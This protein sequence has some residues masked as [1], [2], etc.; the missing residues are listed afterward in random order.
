MRLFH[1]S[2]DAGPLAIDGSFYAR[3]ADAEDARTATIELTV[4]PRS[5]LAWPVRRGQICRI[6]TVEGP[7]AGDFN[8]WSL[9]N[10]RER[11]WAARTRQL[12]GTHVT[13]LGRLWSSRPYHRPMLTIIN[14]TLPHEP[15]ELGGRCH[16]LIGTGCDP[17]IWKLMNGTDFDRTCYNNLARAIAPFHLTEF[18]VHDVLNLF[19]RTGLDPRSGMY[20]M[21]PVPAVKGDYVEFFA[22]IDLLCALSSCPAGDISVP[23]LGPNRGDPS[24]TCRPLGVE[25]FDVE[26]GLLQHWSSPDVVETQPVYGAMSPSA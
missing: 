5:G 12:E 14:D 22:E 20:F 2:A 10:P 4:P 8:A 11:F 3:L 21:E 18:D 17:F 25:V 6:T 7:Q 9:G 13:T 26:D 1:D 15:S 16:D 19:M 24:P 23:H